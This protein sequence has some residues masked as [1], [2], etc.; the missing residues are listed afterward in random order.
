MNWQPTRMAF[1]TASVFL[2]AG[3]HSFGAQAPVGSDKSKAPPS[4]N[5]QPDH[6]KT[7]VA[8]STSRGSH[9]RGTV[10]PSVIREPSQGR[11]IFITPGETFY[12]V[13]NLPQSFTGDVSFALQHALEPDLQYPLRPKTPPSYLND[14]YCSLVLEVRPSTPLGLYDLVVKTSAATHYSRRSVK[15]VGKFKDKFRFVHLSNM[16]VGDLTAPEFDEMLPKEVNLLAPEFI[17]A[18]GD[19]TE[20]ARALDDASSWTRVLRYFEKFN[21][22]VFM[23]CGLHDH[24]AS[25]AQFVASDPIGTI[26][27]GNYHGLLL[28]DHA[29]NPIDQDYSQIQ[30]VDADLKRHR[31]RRMNFIVSNSDELGLID[32]WRE[33]GNIRK[34]M[35]DHKVKLY[36]AGGSSDWD[37]KEFAAK[38]KGLDGFH[39]IRTH[40]S[41]TCMRDRATGFSHYR[42]IEVDGDKL[43]YTYHPDDAAEKLQ[44]SIPT[45][46]LRAYLDAPNDGTAGR[47]VATVQNALNQSFRDARIWLRLAK[48]GDDAKPIVAPGRLVRVLDVGKYWACEVAFDLPDKGAVRIVASMNAADLPPA[49]PIAVA[50]EGSR[51]W[52]FTA[53]TTDFGLNYFSSRAP[54]QLKLTNQSETT[55]SCWP[56]IRLNGAKLHPDRKVVPRVPMLLKPGQTVSLPLMLNLR[57][58]SPGAHE[59]QVYF[60]EDP[61]SRLKTFDVNLSFQEAVSKIQDESTMDQNE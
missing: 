6:S 8:T 11:P 52:A 32:V 58:V 22:P 9:S 49:P 36:I 3:I 15:V 19:Y 30:W 26:D 1:V 4:K 31:Q 13:M 16:N 48:Q 59:L 55:Q 20:W 45:G 34:F 12:F 14:E 18:T 44:Y 25:F 61:L 24:E 56:V 47:I 38:L 21:A 7:T 33:R 23:L 10:T 41:S 54:A 39:F 51:N 43:S 42:V 50:F 5:A 40:E 29:G 60:L 46:R 35:D 2:F 37:Y 28:L 57:R 17:V 53:E 27:Y